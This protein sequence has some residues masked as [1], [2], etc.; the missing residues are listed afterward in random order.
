[1][2]GSIV[3]HRPDNESEQGPEIL[4]VQAVGGLRILTW[5][6]NGIRSLADFP[7][8]LQ[9]LPADVICLQETKVTRDMLTESVSL[10]PGF[11]SYFSFSRRRTGY[12]GV[13][14]FCRSNVTPA[15]AEEGIAGSL[16]GPGDSLDPHL[17]S[18]SSLNNIC[19]E[20]SL[21]S[22]RALDNEGRCVIT[23]HK[24]EGG[25][26]LSIFNL[27][28]PRADPER[29]DRKRFK[30]QFYRAVDLRAAALR[31]RGDSVIVLG[32]INTSHREED[33]CEPYLGFRDRADRRFL[34]HFILTPGDQKDLGESYAEQEDNGELCQE[35]AGENK[36]IEEFSND[37]EWRGNFKL[38]SRQFVDTFRI[39]HPE[40][41]QVFTCWNT[42][43]GCRATNY[44]TRIDYIFASLDI[45]TRLASC[46][47][48]GEVEGSDHCPVL[49]SFDLSLQPPERPPKMATMYFTEFGGRQAKL[50]SYFARG[51][52]KGEGK[53]KFEDLPIKGGVSPAGQASAKRSKAE[54]KKITS[55][56]APKSNKNLGDT[57][58]NQDLKIQKEDLDPES[59]LGLEE[60]SASCK[61]NQSVVTATSG[62]AKSVGSAKDNSS[63]VNAWSSMF[64][65]AAV[66]APV[67]A[68]HSEPCARR[69]VSKSLQVSHLGKCAGEQERSKHWERV[70]VLC[71][72]RGKTG[73][74]S[75]SV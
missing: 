46:E 12:S 9:E 24:I 75:G 6:I 17:G 42:E 32:D 21:E 23:R 70:L 74:P 3:E 56:F 7:K 39:L 65:K 68:G 73:R 71:S 64:N 72:R 51:A 26:F 20:F 40:A 67:C 14:T 60:K 22:R 66:V 43:K 59:R 33:H 37:S 35:R 30:L 4:E 61:D 49:A 2:D 29:E 45:R 47:V 69:K 34:D 52:V 16:G 36:D 62:A 25:K 28:C 54:K 11:T 10:L 58:D 38:P 31:D 5:N 18:E 19:T 44:G 15:Q 27:Y 8:V 13:A 57:N 48:L 55:F 50:S 41:R 53:R 1:M 63:A